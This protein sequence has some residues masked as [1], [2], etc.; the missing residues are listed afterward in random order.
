MTVG[1]VLTVLRLHRA[2]IV[3]TAALLAV[4]VVISAIHGSQTASFIDDH[5]GDGCLPLGCRALAV[6][7]RD[8]S[9]IGLLLVSYVGLMPA[10]VG[11]LWGAPLLGREFET[12]TVTFAWTQSVSRRSWIM[13]SMI[14][15]GLLVALGGLVVGAV[16]SRWLGVFDGFGVQGANDDSFGQVRGVA[17]VGWWVFGFALGALSGALLRRTL[18][19]IVVTVGIMVVATIARN[20]V[21]SLLAGQSGW[22][23][24]QGQLIETVALLGVSV[25]FAAIT[26]VAV[27]R[28]RA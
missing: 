13:T 15:L 11:A 21:L 7:V 22:S 10:A 6:E 8:R 5:R 23:V 28:A 14:T 26:V 4:I 12:H 16:V 20:L 2:Q 3:A 25:L 1:L 9:R 27:E 17:P 19:A 24:Q 18:P